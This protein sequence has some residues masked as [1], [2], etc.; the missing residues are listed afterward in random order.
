MNI[1]EE[2]WGYKRM[3]KK[4]HDLV[5]CVKDDTDNISMFLVNIT[6]KHLEVIDGRQAIR[7]HREAD[8]ELEQGYYLLTKD[9][10]LVPVEEDCCEVEIKFPK[11]NVI[12]SRDLYTKTAD[13]KI[14]LEPLVA[15]A[16]A[17]NEFG[18]T[19]PLDA[20]RKT[21]EAIAKL[22]P[23]YSRIMGYKEAKN[24]KEHGLHIEF[25]VED[26]IF[27]Y[28]V[29]QKDLDKKQYL[30]VNQE[31]CLFDLNKKKETAA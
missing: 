4:W 19:I 2:F 10:V 17:M 11:L 20:H 21:F 8:F 13:F 12:F 27:E 30:T 31:P 24:A 16:H 1:F 22:C 28:V 15:M 26:V 7:I 29:M 3:L 25:A 14:G 18:C 6:K 23:N 9:R 5:M